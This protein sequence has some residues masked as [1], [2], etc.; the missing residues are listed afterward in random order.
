M[1]EPRCPVCG[2]PNPEGS[3]TCQ[4]CGT[5]LKPPAA[6]PSAAPASIRPGEEPVKKNTAEFEKVSLPSSERQPI[7]PGEEPTKKNTAE[8]ERALPTW[9]KTLRDKP[10]TPPGEPPSQTPAQATPATSAEES[11]TPPPPPL[12]SV[13]EWLS[14]LGSAAA[15]E[16][17]IP[18]WLASLRSK[19]GTGPDEPE[20]LTA[21]PQDAGREQGST[22]AGGPPPASAPPPEAPPQ[23]AAGEGLPDW[24]KGLQSEGPESAKQE[25]AAQP[26]N[27]DV[28]AWLS[29]LPPTPPA[30]AHPTP[31][32]ELPDWLKKLKEQA[33]ETES[34]Q[35]PASA[36]E[37]TPE[38]LTRLQ[39]EAETQ[40]D[41]VQ[42]ARAQHEDI[43]DWLS[44][45]ETKAGT[46]ATAPA[47]PAFSG[48]VPVSP[49]ELNGPPPDWLSKLQADVT[50]ASEAEAKKEEFEAAPAPSPE[51]LPAEPLPA[52]LSGVQ[53]EVPRPGGTPALIIGNE[54]KGPPS[55]GEAAF[56]METPDWLSKLK[57]EP[58]P[59]ETPAP[60]PGTGEQQPSESLEPGDLPSWVQAMR[61]VEAVVAEAKAVAPAE[62]QVTTEQNGPLAGLRGVLPAVPGLGP[63]RKPPAYATKLQASETQQRY[64]DSLEKLVYA[65][66]SP[67]A[68]R[69]TLRI[70]GHLLRWVIVLLLFLAVGL[71]IVTGA[72]VVPP[73]S[74]PPV[75]EV[76]ATYTLIGQ[77]APSS[78]V[79]VVFDYEPAL[80]GELEAA[81]QNVVG[82][83]IST[84]ALLTFISTSPTG[85]ALADHFLQTT[86][87]PGK[88]QS[89]QTYINLGYLAGGPTGILNFASWPGKAA[90]YAWS[91]DPKVDG[92]NAWVMPPLLGVVNLSDF[93][94]VFVLTDSADTGRNWIEQAGPSLG[95]T[96]ML[97]VISAQAEPM[98]RPYYDSGQLKGLVT[99][100]A[101]GKAYEQ[102][103]QH[104]GLGQAYWNSFSTGLLMAE[105]LI[106]VGGAWSAFLAWRENRRKEEEA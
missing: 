3:E 15:E 44:K 26:D 39:A 53:P 85:P 5:R 37:L 100:L 29:N 14:G 57:P 60:V 13:P 18:D 104:P 83:L 64:A 54:D 92:N 74:L 105:I 94:A 82:Q 62:G 91:T 8:L 22:P 33:A 21:F 28:S 63:L 71:P 41:A 59:Q 72:Q 69:S 97:M 47:S 84:G 77:L 81:A 49:T 78:Q 2:Q 45:L 4:F 68:I 98:M 24:L 55:A 90:P 66:N 51:S 67:H 65:E 87:P 56:S 27:P 58:G 23:G 20:G 10:D 6:A 19:G 40:E 1:A 93:K 75:E 48:E 99:G 31:A 11:S 35:P 61:P 88:L 7:H 96:P 16:Q 95:S 73:T 36:T 38:W 9:L 46:G 52:W 89:G 25:P 32:E 79:L 34:S 17:E 101:G 80:S 103:V 70:S 43:P 102:A 76:Q 86:Q 12:N 30:E 106:L 50:A 42:S